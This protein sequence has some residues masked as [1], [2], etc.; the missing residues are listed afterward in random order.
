M[1]IILI[2]FMGSGKSTVAAGLARRLGLPLIDTDEAVVS[3][4]GFPS[5][6]NIFEVRGEQ[7]FRDFESE[8]A[9]A[10]GTV[11]DG[12]VSTGGGI[13]TRDENMT[14]LKKAGDVVVYLRTSFDTLAARIG[15][16]ETRPLFKNRLNARALYEQRHPIYERWADVAIDT[17]TLSPDDVCSAIISKLKS[18]S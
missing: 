6:A 13:V 2:G 3:R 1:K 11:E 18:P 8:V 10:T 4:A 9:K 7:V 17:D 15:D 14:H 16:L 12:V 5:I